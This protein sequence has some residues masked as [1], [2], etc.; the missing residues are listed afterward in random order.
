[1]EISQNFYTPSQTSVLQDPTITCVRKCF[2]FLN[3]GLCIKNGCCRAFLVK[4]SQKYLGVNE[5]F[6]NMKDVHM[7]V[8]YISKESNLKNSTTMFFRQLSCETILIVNLNEVVHQN[9]NFLFLNLK[10]GMLD[11][12]SIRIEC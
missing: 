4:Y 12:D 6:F 11:W 5:V 2:L 9:W 3:F 10:F 7:N 1:M 8:F